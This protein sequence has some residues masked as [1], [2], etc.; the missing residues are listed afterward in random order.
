MNAPEQDVRPRLWTLETP[1][2]QPWV[3]R[4]QT[5]HTSRPE[6]C[7]LRGEYGER[8]RQLAFYR[9]WPISWDG[10]KNIVG[11]VKSITFIR[12][13]EDRRSSSMITVWQE[14]SH[15]AVSSS[16][17]SLVAELPLT[18]SIPVSSDT[19]TIAF[20]LVEVEYIDKQQANNDCYYSNDWVC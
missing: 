9:S 18:Q 1:L 14:L 19:D 17:T 10:N 7:S 11:R 3:L 5:T 8:R 12:S 6:A 20:F 16:L 13:S 15:R 2:L 4:E